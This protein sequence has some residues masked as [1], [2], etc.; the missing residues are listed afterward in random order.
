MLARKKKGRRPSSTVHHRWLRPWFFLYCLYWACY[1]QSIK[2]SEKGPEVRL[3]K[4]KL[5][6]QSKRERR[7]RRASRWAL[8]TSA[9]SQKKQNASAAVSTLTRL[10]H[11]KLPVCCCW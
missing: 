7:R 10:C 9:G 6:R 1:G 4:K 5:N 2:G 11:S 8:L 3:K